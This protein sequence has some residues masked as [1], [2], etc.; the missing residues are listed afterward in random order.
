MA[1][2]IS[3]QFWNY[4]YYVRLDLDMEQEMPEKLEM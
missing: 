1:N 2:K 3:N 4:N